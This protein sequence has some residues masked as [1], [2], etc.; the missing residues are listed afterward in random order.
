MPIEEIETR[1]YLRFAVGDH[2]GVLGHIASA[3]GAESVSIEQ[4]VQE[5]LAIALGALRYQRSDERSGYRNGARNRTLTA[6]TGTS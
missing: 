3:L 5:E 2:P 1:Y 4:M 6:Q